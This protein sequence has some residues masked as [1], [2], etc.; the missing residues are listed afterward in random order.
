MSH[1][2]Q[3][4]TVPTV[5][6]NIVQLCSAQLCSAQL[7][8]AQLCSVQCSVVQQFE[9]HNQSVS[10]VYCAVFMPAIRVQSGT[11]WHRPGVVFAP[12]H[13]LVTGTP[14]G[15]GKL[16]VVR[17][18]GD[19]LLPGEAHTHLSGPGDTRILLGFLSCKP[20][21]GHPARRP[22]LVTSPCFLLPFGPA[23][24][25]WNTSFQTTDIIQTWQAREGGLYISWNRDELSCNL[26]WYSDKQN[27]NGPYCHLHSPLPMWG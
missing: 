3:P 5:Y 9:E 27:I 23:R 1:H 15:A 22:L 6:T 4:V 10:C 19:T 24:L 14:Q 2:G 16:P 26:N 13:G 7:C 8:S 11:V 21:S 20:E 18:A 12:E 25:G 17:P